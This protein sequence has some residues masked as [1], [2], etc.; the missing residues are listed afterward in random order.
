MGFFAYTLRRLIELVPVLLGVTLAAFLL[1]RVMPGDPATLILG[2]RGDEKDIAALQAQLGLDRP[3][4]EQYLRFVRDVATG[5]FG[6]SIAYG[7]PVAGLIWERLP[8][9][10]WLVA[11]STILAVLMAVPAAVVAA[12]RRGGPVDLA[13]R[14]LLVFA[15]ATPSF[16]LGI[17]LILALSLKFGL[18]PVSGYGEG[19][20]GRLWH[21]FLPSLV[22]ALTTAAIVMRNLRSSILAVL[23]ADFIDS[24][25]A[26]GL[27]SR[28]VLLRHVL[29]NALISAVS[30]LGVH[31]SWIIGGT[32]VIE[33]VFGVPGLGNLLIS[34]IFGRDYP[35]VQGLT[36]AFALL[37]V[38]INLA[39]DLAYAAIDPRVSLD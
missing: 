26:K 4:W 12:L 30:V 39:T 38:L 15:L 10:L 33:A 35:L 32:V 19:L 16:W 7:R 37:V 31:T 11:Y 24:A 25:R 14:G 2:T 36:V 34:S 21:L 3:L 20:A 13:L 29:P 18:F 5:S 23:N 28:R 22:I 8:A 1:L 6:Q 17:L 9:S 27:S